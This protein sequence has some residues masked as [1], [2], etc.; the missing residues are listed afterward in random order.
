MKY[1]W[2]KIS[3]GRVS[4]A[5][6][7]MF[8]VPASFT[9]GVNCQIIP[10]LFTD[11]HLVLMELILSPKSFWR[12]NVKLLHGLNYCENLKLFWAYWRS[13][14]DDFLSLTQLW[15][16]GK[17]QIRVFCQEYK[18]SDAINVKRAVQELE[19]E[20]RDLEN[21]L[22]TDQQNN[23]RL[24]SKKQ[25]LNSFLQERAKGALVRAHFT[26]LQDIDAPT[27]FFFNLEKS[28]AS[29]IRW[30][31]SASLMEGDHRPNGDEEACS[32]LLY[33]LVQGRQL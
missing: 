14:K 28:V 23:D 12:F 20:I 30:C 1:T 18:A 16:V 29:K 17:A 33:R 10:V 32:G 25:E 5:R 22:R 7:D 24:Q 19:G 15:E 11:Y 26:R 4:A 2:I 8:Y 27:T 6:L 21:A 9:A 13:Q 3:D 31:V